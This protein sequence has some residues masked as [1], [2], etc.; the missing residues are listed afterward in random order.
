MQAAET[1]IAEQRLNTGPLVI[2][3]PGG[4]FGPSKLWPP[5]RYAEV[6]NALAKDGAS[7]LLSVA[8]NEVKDAETV[9]MAAGRK[10]PTSAGLDLGTL[11]A[12]YE[13]ASLVLTNDAGPRHIAVAL[14]K[15]VV[16]VMG[17]NDPRY[18]ALPDV[19]R[20]EVIRERVEC[21]AVHLALPVEGMPD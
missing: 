13:R 3:A 5:A 7:V 18:T 4:A 20:G 16:C 17:P 1:F 8:P 21:P 14:G 15:P 10:Y 11:K 6:L 19:E 9:N 2:C 12:V